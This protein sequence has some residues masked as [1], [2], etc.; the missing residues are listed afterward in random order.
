MYLF[1]EA[2]RGGAL[3]MKRGASWIDGAGEA[4]GRRLRTFGGRNDLHI[5]I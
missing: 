3:V 4:K 1:G 5:Y 2:Y